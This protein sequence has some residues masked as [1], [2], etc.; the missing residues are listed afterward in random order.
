MMFVVIG[1]INILIGILV[2]FLLPANPQSAKFLSS[3]KKRVVLSH[4]AIT[5]VEST[6]PKNSQ[7]QARSSMPSKIHRLGSCVSS[8]SFAL[9]QVASSPLSQRL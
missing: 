8:R 9:C 1:V 7:N 2:V 3:E 5:R 6:P 4:L